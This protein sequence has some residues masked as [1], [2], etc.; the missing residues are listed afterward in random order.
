MESNLQKFNDVIEE[1]KQEH[2]TKK[3]FG[4]FKV[5]FIHNIIEVTANKIKDFY[6]IKLQFQEDE[7]KKFKNEVSV[8]NE[9]IKQLKE[10]INILSESNVA[11]T[12]EIET[13][14]A[15]EIDI[16]EK[17][18]A[19]EERAE[20]IIENAKVEAAESYIK[21]GNARIQYHKERENYIN[22]KK[23]TKEQISVVSELLEQISDKVKI[24]HIHHII[25]DNHN[26][27]RK[28]DKQQKPNEKVAQ[29][30]NS[31]NQQSRGEQK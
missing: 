24:D 22:W 1:I 12:G 5:P 15:L 27:G 26:I 11:L 18:R 28:N 14:N 16:A 10:K 7:T 9:E 2:I 21:M 31:Q 13:L 29:K 8:L 23:N 20:E 6:E 30:S 17:L 19:V 3:P 4:G 25:S